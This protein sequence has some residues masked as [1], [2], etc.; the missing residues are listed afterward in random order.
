M[1]QEAI[2]KA[3]VEIQCVENCKALQVTLFVIAKVHELLHEDI[4]WMCLSSF[5]KAFWNDRRRDAMDQKRFAGLG[6][7]ILV[8]GSALPRRSLDSFWQ[9]PTDSTEGIHNT[10]GTNCQ[11]ECR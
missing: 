7:D 6:M 4:D 3:I 11:K 1:L 8:L 2:S 5:C 9:Q 10:S